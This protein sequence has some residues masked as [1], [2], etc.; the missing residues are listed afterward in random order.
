MGEFSIPASKIDAA[1]ELASL[2]GKIISMSL[3]LGLVTRLMTRNLYTVLHSRLGWCRRLTLSSEAYQEIN[4]WLSE[5]T[6]FNSGPSP[7]QSE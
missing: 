1:R 5:I 7:V 4:F 6:K 2:I 3:A